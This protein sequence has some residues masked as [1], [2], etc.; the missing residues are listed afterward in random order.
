M[1]VDCMVKPHAIPGYLWV[2]LKQWKMLGN[3]PAQLCSDDTHFSE[4]S[5]SQTYYILHV[6]DF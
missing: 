6:A 2:F 1:R 3:G 5:F 4:A